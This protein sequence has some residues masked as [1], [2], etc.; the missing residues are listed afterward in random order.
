[1]CDMEY[2]VAG[3]ECGVQVCG[4]HCCI[5]QD[6]ENYDVM[7][8]WCGIVVMKNVACAMSC[9][10]MSDVENDAVCCEICYDVECGCGVE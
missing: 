4:R 6:V 1:M 9:C 5:M 7:L 3:V 8:W 10:V 2:G